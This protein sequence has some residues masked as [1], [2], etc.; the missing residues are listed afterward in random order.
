MIKFYPKHFFLQSYVVTQVATYLSPALLYMYRKWLLSPEFV[1]KLFFR[2]SLL[3][4]TLLTAFLLRSY[5]RAANPKYKAFYQDLMN[6]KTEYSIDNKVRIM[7]Y[8]NILY[9]F[10]NC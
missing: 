3:C 10:D 2:G 7:S 8:V 6:A 1:N 5:G 9:C 4:V